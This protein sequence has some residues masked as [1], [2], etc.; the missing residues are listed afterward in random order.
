M[1]LEWHPSGACVRFDREGPYLHENAAHASPHVKSIFINGSGE[2]EIKHA[3]DGRKISSILVSPDETLAGDRGI[4]G[5]GSG[6]TGTTRIRFFD[7][8]LGRRLYL[9]R[10]GDYARME[11]P[12]S[13]VWIMWLHVAEV[14]ES[15]TICCCGQS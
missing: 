12:W 3:G 6:G 2:L 13:N 7:A 1:N 10:P 4:S 5:G 14:E 11:G 9:N 8:C 15:P